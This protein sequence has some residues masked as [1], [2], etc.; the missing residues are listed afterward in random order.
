MKALSVCALALIPVLSLGQVTS[1][2]GSHTLRLKLVP[3]GKVVYSSTIRFQ[4]T[5]SAKPSAAACS[6]STSIGNSK[7]GWFGLTTVTSPLTLNGQTITK[8]TVVKSEVNSSGESRNGDAVT[9][10]ATYPKRAIKIGQ[11][12]KG[13]AAVS[14]ATGAAPLRVDATFTLKSVGNV[15]GRRVATIAFKFNAKSEMNLA[16]GGTLLVSAE[17]GWMETSTTNLEMST[18]TKPIKSTS[19]LVRVRK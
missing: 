6:L 10:M 15:K 11:S 12:W 5:P 4:L 1:K 13:R 3:N 18:S 7:G 9:V 19:T 2:G 14:G 8:E 17:D 16:G